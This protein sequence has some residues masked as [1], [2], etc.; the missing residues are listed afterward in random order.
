MLKRHLLKDIMKKLVE[1][2]TFK[3]QLGQENIKKLDTAQ[4]SV[5]FY[6]YL[7]MIGF[8]SVENKKISASI[9]RKPKMKFK[10]SLLTERQIICLHMISICNIK[11]KLKNLLKKY[12]EF[13]I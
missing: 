4:Q 1:Y 9:F 10:A 3:N 13:F 6:K 2:E 7:K 11:Y 5:N 12:Y 8:E